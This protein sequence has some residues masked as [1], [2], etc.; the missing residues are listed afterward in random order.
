MQSILA[1][2]TGR[3]MWQRLQIILIFALVVAL[4]A[5]GVSRAMVAAT[6]AGGAVHG[7][8]DGLAAGLHVNHSHTHH[9][10]DR[11]APDLGTWQCLKHCVEGASDETTITSAVTTLAPPSHDGGGLVKSFAFQEAPTTISASLAMLAR[12]PPPLGH[13]G[14]PARPQSVLVRNARLRI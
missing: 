14:A 11:G 2:V 5:M 9:S 1:E 13:V 10:H 3:I 12:G 6:P 7:V 8:G 4:P